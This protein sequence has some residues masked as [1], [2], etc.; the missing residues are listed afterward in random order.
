M[1]HQ[2]LLTRGYRGHYQ[3][4]KM[5]VA[6]LRRGLPIDTPRDRPPSPR[7]VARWITTAPSRRTLHASEQLRRLFAHCPELDRTHDLVRQ[8]AAMLDTRDAAP[9]PA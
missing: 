8:F 1:L 4:I 2:E 6:P 7:Q 3:R 5:A 9:L